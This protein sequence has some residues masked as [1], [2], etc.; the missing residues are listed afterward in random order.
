MA[1]RSVWCWPTAMTTRPGL[2]RIRQVAKSWDM[3]RYAAKEV[4]LSR[5]NEIERREID[6]AYAICMGLIEKERICH[7]PSRR[8]SSNGLGQNCRAD[9]CWKERAD[10]HVMTDASLEEMAATKHKGLPTKV[11]AKKK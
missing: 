1:A 2:S 6:W 3:G 11:K 4:A 7:L 10:C 5:S 8:S 9:A